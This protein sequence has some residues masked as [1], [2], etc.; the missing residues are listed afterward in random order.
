LFYPPTNKGI[1][2]Y[3]FKVRLPCHT[4]KQQLK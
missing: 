4:K 3:L 1:E 2:K